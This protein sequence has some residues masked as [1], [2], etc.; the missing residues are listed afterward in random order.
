MNNPIALLLAFVAVMF[1]QNR[2]HENCTCDA[3]E[4][5]SGPITMN[6]PTQQQAPIKDPIDPRL[7]AGQPANRGFLF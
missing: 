3:E 7:A 4:E 6:L 1:I 2:L 5:Q